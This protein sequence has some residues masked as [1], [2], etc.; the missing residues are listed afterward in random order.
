MFKRKRKKNVENL[1]HDIANALE[2]YLYMF[3][4]E[5]DYQKPSNW[6]L[7]KPLIIVDLASR[8]KRNEFT[9]NNGKIEYKI[10][11]VCINESLTAFNKKLLGIENER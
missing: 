9:K 10:H 11:R 2:I 4:I 7:D 5:N 3:D 6:N 8:K 1:V